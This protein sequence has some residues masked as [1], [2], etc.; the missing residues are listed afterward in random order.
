[1]MMV[2]TS[3]LVDLLRKSPE[4]LRVIQKLGS[5]PLFTTEISIM[6]LVFGITGSRIYINKPELKQK[7]LSEIGDLSLKFTILPFDRKSA[8]K[9]AEILGRLK[10][11][12]KLVDFR[13]GMIAGVTK[14][15]GI[16][17]LITHN[18]RHFERIPDLKIIEVS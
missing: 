11:D 10:L 15:N 17:E 16:K 3:I 7:R 13:D 2:D 6:E 5:T 18:K 9:T 14:A 1:M 12:G 8:Y 4:I